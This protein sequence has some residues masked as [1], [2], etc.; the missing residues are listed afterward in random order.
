MLTPWSSKEETRSM[1]PAQTIAVNAPSTDSLA[2]VFMVHSEFETRLPALLTAIY[3][4]QHTYMIHVDSSVTQYSWL[5]AQQFVA[6]V[7]ERNGANNVFLVK[8]RIAGAWGSISLVYQE[9]VSLVEL[10]RLEKAGKIPKF[11][12][13][14]NLSAFDYPIKPIGELEAFLKKNEGINFVEM[15]VHKELRR[16][17]RQ[18]VRTFLQQYFNC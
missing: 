5:W 15:L 3:K 13:V 4:T 10:F 8:D 14:I 12:H 9:L 17:Y 6:D 1:K 16:E 7:N 18:T 2:F 11:S